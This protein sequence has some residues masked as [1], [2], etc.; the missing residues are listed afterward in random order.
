MM[1]GDARDEAKAVAVKDG[2]DM[3]VT[4]NPYDE[5]M[6]KEAYGFHPLSAHHIFEHERLVTIYRANSGDEE[7]KFLSEDRQ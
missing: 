5:A 4:H 6:W 3:A 1:L 2:I 7:P